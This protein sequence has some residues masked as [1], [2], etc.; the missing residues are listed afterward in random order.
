[1]TVVKK[2]L[3]KEYFY[4][5]IINFLKNS[6]DLTK[7]QKK[8][9]IEK[10]NLHYYLTEMVKFGYIEKKG[11]GWYEVKNQLEQ[12]K[13]STKYDN[14]LV[15]DMSRG[16]AYVWNIYLSKKPIG[17]KNRLNKIKKKKVNHV[18][19]GA[20][21]TTPRIKVM[22]RKVW[23]CND[24]IR[25]FDIEKAS[26][27][28][29]TAK[30]SRE[31]ST[32]KL[33]EIVTALENKLGF[34]LKPFKFSIQKE[35]YALIRNDLAIHHNQKGIIMRIEDEEGE[36]LLIDDSLGEGGELE[37]IGKKAYKNNQ[38]LQT[39]WNE[40]KEDGFESTKPS[41]IKKEFS[42]IKEYITETTQII[43]MLS[44]N[45]LDAELRNQQLES[46]L[47]GQEE[48]IYQLINNFRKD[49]K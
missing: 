7:L 25:I 38:P 42:E 10:Q 36:W 13:N 23:L 48:L 37:T 6:T 9:G 34:L 2:R 43:K 39:W 17:W 11:R 35:H 26:Y 1:M 31:K 29:D 14:Q 41:K 32:M 8:L 46:R 15:K 12:S 24:H 30:E 22:G 49:E 47:R 19:V 28:G 33:Y 18:L 20:L 44:K 16:H 3:G 40:L 4:S 21:K 27:Y 45:H 5:T